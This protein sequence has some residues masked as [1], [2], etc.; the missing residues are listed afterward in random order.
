MKWTFQG[1]VE[2]F[3]KQQINAKAEELSMAERGT[4]KFLSC[5]RDA[6]SAVCKELSPEEKE[7]YEALVDEWN[8]KSAPVEVQ[9]E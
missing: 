7:K 4:P 2:Q 1:V 8:T 3:L 5:Y 9:R 6:R